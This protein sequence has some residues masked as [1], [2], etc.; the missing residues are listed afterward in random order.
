MLRCIGDAKTMRFAWRVTFLFALQ[1]FATCRQR[2]LCDWLFCRSICHEFYHQ[3]SYFGTLECTKLTVRCPIV[4]GIFLE[5]ICWQSH[6]FYPLASY[7]KGVPRYPRKSATLLFTLL[8]HTQNVM[9]L[10]QHL[11]TIKYHSATSNTFLITEG[12]EI[13]RGLLQ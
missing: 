1:F 5:P 4:T 7:K 13:F 10:F 11:P 6:Y 8:L 3:V 9:T 2:T 12:A